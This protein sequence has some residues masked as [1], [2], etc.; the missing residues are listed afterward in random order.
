LR[1]LEE[2]RAGVLAVEKKAEGLL[3][4]MIGTTGGLVKVD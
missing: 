2:I 1:T 3:S 4:A